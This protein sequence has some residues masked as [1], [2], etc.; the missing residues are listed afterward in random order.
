MDRTI[1]TERLLL[2]A[3]KLS[4]ANWITKGLSNFTVAGNMLVPHPFEIDHALEWL[5]QEKNSNVPAEA[6]FCID[7]Q[8]D[9]GVGSVSFRRKS[10]N[11]QLG[12]WLDEHYWGRG[13]MSEAVKAAV[14]WYYASTRADI[15][16]SGV[17]HFNMA[18]LAVQH[19]LGFVETGRSEVYCPARAADI[20]H[21][22]TELTREAF[23]AAI[24]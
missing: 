22:D 16:T 18:S 12:Y 7:H 10:G 23:E 1:H 9:G 11:A 8:K 17:F 13:I 6:Q 15:I 2:R 24:I 5:L 14:Q 4:D 19:K 20:E 21:I 3:P